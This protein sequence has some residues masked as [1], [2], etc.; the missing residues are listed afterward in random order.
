MYLV[1]WFDVSWTG[2][3]EVSGEAG[4]QVYHAGTKLEGNLFLTS[5]GRVMAVTVTDSSLVAAAAKAMV[6]AS[7]I[8]FEGAFFRKD[9]A[10]KAITRSAHWT[11]F[12]CVWPL[13]AKSCARR[14]VF[15]LAV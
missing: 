10:S 2:L 7:K 11:Y 5:G 12:S 3:S 9:I 8:S 4:V 13:I 15:W 14:S 6:T 1:Y